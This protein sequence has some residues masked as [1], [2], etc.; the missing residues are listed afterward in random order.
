MSDAECNSE[1]KRVIKA[2]TQEYELEDGAKKVKHLSWSWISESKNGKLPH[3][4]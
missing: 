2:E 4:L 3:H 1:S